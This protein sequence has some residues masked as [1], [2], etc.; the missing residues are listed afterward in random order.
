MLVI[1][2]KTEYEMLVRVKMSKNITS[3]QIVDFEFH[4]QN[5]I[6]LASSAKLMGSR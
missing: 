4:V 1:N 3:W 6:D 5:Q 2:L